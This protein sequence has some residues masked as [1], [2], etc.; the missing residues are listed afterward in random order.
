MARHLD[1]AVGSALLA[2]RRLIYDDSDRPVQ[3]LHGLYRPDRYEY[4]MKLY[5]LVARRFIAVFYPPAKY[6]VTKRI[7]TVEGETFKTDGKI[8]REPGWLEVYG[9]EGAGD[10]DDPQ[11]AVNTGSTIV[12]GGSIPYDDGPGG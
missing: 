8:L 10:A 3:W 2:V 1:V 11:M 7:T 9:K 6:E 12:I 4:E 5:D